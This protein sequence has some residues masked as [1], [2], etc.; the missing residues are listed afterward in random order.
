[1]PV[2]INIRHL[3][4]KEIDL[5]GEVSAA[6][7]DLESLDE[8]IQVSKPVRYE[9]HAQ[10]M[11]HEI[12]VRGRVSFSLDCEC[13]RCL[14]KFEYPVEFSD[15][16][17]FLPLEGEEKV[18]IANDCVDLTPYLREDILLEFPQHPLCGMDCAGLPNRSDVTAKKPGA[19]QTQNASAWS[20][21]N[22]LKF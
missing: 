6:E 4:D 1:M 11:S 15:W 16:T 2:T 5:A 20:E 8:L 19:S 14:K 21:L 12:L 22:K 3:E 18:V 10:K 7:L 13:V 17:C 9:L